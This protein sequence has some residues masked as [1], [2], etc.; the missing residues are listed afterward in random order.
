MMAAERI[1]YQDTNYR[2]SIPAEERLSICLRFLAT[3]DS[4]RTI[5]GSFRAGISTVSMLIPD[6]VAAIWDCLV[7]EFMAVPGAE[8]W[9]SSDGGIVSNSAFACELMNRGILALVSSIGCMSAGS[10]Q[11]LADAMHIP[12]L[13]IQRSPR[14]SPRSSCPPI[15]HLPGADDYT[16]MVRPPVYLNEVIMQVV[17]EY[18][19][20]KFVLFYDSDFGFSFVFTARQI[21]R[22][23][24][25][26]LSL[27]PQTAPAAG[28]NSVIQEAVKQAPIQQAPIQQAPIQQAPI[29][30]API[31]QALIQQALMQ[32]APIQQ[33]PIQQAPIQQAPIQQALIQQA[34]IQQA[35]I[36][37]APIQQ[38]PI[39]Q[40][41]MQQALM[42]QAPIQQAPIQ[43]APIQQ[44]PIQQALIQQAL[45][46]QAP[47]QQAPI[48]QAPIQQAPIQQALMQQ[49]PIQQALI[50]QAP[51]QQ[52]PIQQALIQQAPI[53]QAPIQQAPI[54]QA[55]MQQAPIQ[56]A[57]IQQALIQ[58]ALSLSHT[59]TYV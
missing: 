18:S 41:P 3:G 6:V 7:E 20:Q 28:K 56:Q 15:S 16:L 14:G 30:Q 26:G 46:Q 4:Y 1:S 39:Q 36:Q 57:P 40:A 47:M 38:A 32:Q 11:T 5:A 34:P 33:A 31:Q 50:Q 27:R 53:Q 19:W 2:R 25:N 52:A 23:C 49:A 17:S 10:L 12:H 51:I 42:Q 58:Q 59:H 22:I 9:R 29:Q 37:Q 24:A 44:A 21:K 43:Q 54:Q 55:L 35:P 48:Q 13:F 8:E 45:I